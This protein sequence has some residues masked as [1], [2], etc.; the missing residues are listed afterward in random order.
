M[1][2]KLIS[3]SLGVVFLLSTVGCEQLPGTHKQ[4]GAVIGG[5][6]GAVAGAVIGGEKHRWLGALIGGA[7]GATGGYLIGAQTEKVN[8][9]DRDAALEANRRAETRPATAEEAAAA[10]TADINKD[11]FVTLDEVVAM[12][13]AG[14]TDDQM[15]TR[16]DATDQIFELTPEQQRY[17]L[18][19]GVSRTVVDRLPNLN[20]EQQNNIR[21]TDVISEPAR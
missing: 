3:L 10:T 14:L 8:N 15:I 21:R 7:L 12:E 5:T 11:G 1:S 6:G 19:R 20:R 9:N 2:K 13:K 16:L 18:D 4:Q 17:L